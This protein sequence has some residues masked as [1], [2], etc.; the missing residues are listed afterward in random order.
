MALGGVCVAGLVALI[1][2]AGW[3]LTAG[4]RSVNMFGGLA[5]MSGFLAF[6]SARL[7]QQAGRPDFD[8]VGHAT[9]IMLDVWNIFIRL[10]ILMAESSTKK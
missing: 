6:D 1:T 2:P 5:V 10:V 4:L 8:P 7:R 3:G 9:E